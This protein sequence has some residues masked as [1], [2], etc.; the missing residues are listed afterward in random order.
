VAKIEELFSELDAGEESLRVARRQLGVYRQSLLKQA[1]EGKLTEK[2][3]TQN[4]H[5]LESPEQ[6]LKRIQASRTAKGLR[7][8]KTIPELIDCTRE[9]LPAI[10]SEWHWLRLEH[11]AI[12]GTGMS[13][14]QARTYDDAVEVPYLRVANV[15]RGRLDLTEMR[16]MLVERSRLDE[17]KVK[18][19]DVLFNEGGDRDKLGRGWVWNGQIDPCI[20]QNHVFRATA[21]STTIT[22]P[23]YISHWGNAFGQDFFHLTGKQTTNL[24]SISKATLSSLPVPLP[25]FEEQKEILRLLDEQFEAIERNEREI[26]AALRR[27]EALRQAILKKAFTGQLVAQDPADEPASELLTRLQAERQKSVATKSRSVKK[28]RTCRTTSGRYD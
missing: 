13:V 26:D 9:K 19:G 24:A 1:F 8:S 11:V 7:P 4:P 23:E 2:W 16:T 17:L 22:V 6:L 5:L 15:Q 28:A 21:I 20:T 14:S 3:R 10:P 12:I 25:P 18:A 27:S